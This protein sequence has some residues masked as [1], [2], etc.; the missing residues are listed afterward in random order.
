MEGDF[1]LPKME[2]HEKLLIAMF[3]F[4]I[5]FAFFCGRWSTLAPKDA[6]VPLPPEVKG[7]TATPKQPLYEIVDLK[8]NDLVSTDYWSH[9][10]SDGKTLHDRRLEANIQKETGEVLAKG[11]CTL[12]KVV[13]AWLQSPTHKDI[14][15]DYWDSAV[16]RFERDGMNCYWVGEYIR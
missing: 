6:T 1:D 14:I 3:I 11:Y 16:I 13:E 2:T 10:N 15:V 9:V 5:L 12:P 8:L 4:S 7:V